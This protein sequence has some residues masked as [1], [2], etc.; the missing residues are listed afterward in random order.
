MCILIL[1][2]NDSMIQLQERYK[3]NQLIGSSQCQIEHAAINNI[4]IAMKTFVRKG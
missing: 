3:S 1:K 2:F 4:T